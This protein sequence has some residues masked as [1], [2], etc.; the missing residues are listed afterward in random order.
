MRATRAAAAAA[1]GSVA[2][3]AWWASPAWAHGIGGRSD[4]PLP[5]WL[6]AYGAGFA[7]LISFVA[8][9]VVWPKPRLEAAAV[10]SAMPPWTRKVLAVILLV[11]RALGLVAFA[12]TFA[13]AAFGTNSAASNLAPVAIYVVFWVGLQVASAVLGG[14]WPVLSPFDTLAAIARRLRGRSTGETL[15]APPPEDFSMWPAAAGIFAFT[16]L[17]LCFHDPASPRI[18]ALALGAY[19]ALMLLGA[20]RWGRAWLRTGD[21]FAAWFGLLAHLS[22]FTHDRHGTPRTRAPFA[23]LATVRPRAGTVPLVLVL[24][25]STTFDGLTRTQQWLDATGAPTG[26]EATIVNTVGMVWCI[27][28][29]ALLY[30]GAMKV[31]AMLTGGEAGELADQFV[32]SLVPIALAYAIA[33][34]FSLLVFEGQD[35]IRLISDPLGRGWDLFGTADRRIDYRAVSTNTIAYVQAAAIVVGHVVGVVAAHDRAL[36]LFPKRVATRSQYPLVA[37]MVVYTVAGLA[38]LLGA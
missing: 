36:E 14:V 5:T 31:T 24:L 17:E 33:H 25:G 28:M 12:L 6:F 11:V 32:H 13:A 19:T 21:G 38:L 18:L 4:L 2:L 1:A 20:A 29:V 3:V 23:G 34:Y 30:A 22:P 37:V 8:L 9:A 16:W 7:V 15:F 35:A 10:G 27:G 26:W